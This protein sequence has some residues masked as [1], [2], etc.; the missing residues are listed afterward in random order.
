VQACGRRLFFIT[1]VFITTGGFTGRL[2]S[3]EASIRKSLTIELSVHWYAANRF[4]STILDL[5]KG[6]RQ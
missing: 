3:R 4:A 5:R 6:H 1:S 2:I